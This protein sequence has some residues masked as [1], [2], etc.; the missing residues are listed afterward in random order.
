MARFEE[1]AREQ[2]LAAELDPLS[3]IIANAAGQVLFYSR[4]YDDAIEA[5]QSVLAREPAFLPAHFNLGQVYLQKK[6]Y[7]EAVA[8][9]EN[10]FHWSKNAGAAAALARALASAGNKT[11]ARELLADL[12]KPGPGTYLASP[13]I[14]LVHFALGDED[15]GFEWMDKG[16]DERS[17]WMTFLKVDPAYDTLRHLPRFKR[18][19]Q[20]LQFEPAISRFAA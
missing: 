4:K 18:L 9:F 14:A 5:F 7:R 11:N 1:A 8:S 15:A 17:Y 13:L 3:L 6:L 10:T 20:R 2:R 16:F 19:M 12:L